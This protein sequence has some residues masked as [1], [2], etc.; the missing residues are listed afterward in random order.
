MVVVNGDSITYTPD[1]NFNGID[2]L[3]YSICDNGMPVL[4]DT[5]TVFITVDPVNDAPV[6]TIDPASTDEDIPV[7]VDV[8]GN[9]T[10]VEGDSLTTTVVGPPS[11]G[12]VVVVN[13]DSISYTPDPNFNG[14]DTLVYS[15]CDNGT[16]VLCDTDTVIITVNPVNDAPVATVDPASTDEDTPVN[17][18]VQNNDSDIDGDPLTTTIVVGPGNGTAV[19]VNGDSITYTPDPNFNGLDTLVY[20]ICDNGTPVLCDT[21]TVFI[22]VDP[23]NDVPVAV[24]DVVM[25]MEDN[26]IVIDPLNNDN[27]LADPNGGLDSN[28]V[29]IVTTPVSGTL[30]PGP[31]GTFSYLP[32]SNFCGLD[33][34]QY[35]VCDNG[36]PAPVLCDTAWVV[37]EVEC[38]NDGPIAIDDNGQ[39]FGGVPIDL[40]V[41]SNDTDIDGDSLMVSGIT[42]PPTNGTVTINPDGSITYLPP[43]GFVGL[44]TF[45][46]V[47]CDN[48]IPSLCDTACV[49]VEVLDNNDP[50]VA[51]N[52]TGST[53]DGILVTLGVLGNDTDPEG[54]SLVVTEVGCGPANGVAFLV[55][56]DSVAYLPNPGF[57]GVDSFC[58]IVCDPLGQCDT[59]YVFIDVVSTNNPPVASSDSVTTSEDPIDIVVL[60][61]DG[62]PNNDSITVSSVPCDP[63]NGSVSI[64]GG[65]LTYTPVD[66]FIGQDSFCYVI[67]DNGI[68]AMCDTAWVYVEVLPIDLTIPN[69]FTPNGDDFNDNFVIRGLTELYPENELQIFNR[70]GNIVFERKNYQNDWD[71]LFERTGEKVPDGTY[72]YKLEIEG[73]QGKALRSG[74]IVIFE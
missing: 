68:P 49:V 38:V 46:Y 56:P 17:V 12:T 40:V 52:D 43:V 45:C 26:P 51:S 29:S 1:P 10:D 71:G 48:G 50:P 5:D 4:C 9:D 44:D 59:A 34:F 73:P 30:T 54:D 11:N 41:V 32:D 23:V 39:T 69:T 8:Q 36:I 15:I 67:C 61:N 22:T 7:L 20:S 60:F 18:D 33:S 2:T 19:V 57:V 25:G 74:Y 6:A 65:I 72:F 16:P 37:I 64:N 53:N 47:I 42:T 21:D 62:D 31:G 13:G 58:Y 55:Q 3:V 66:G 24:D 63:V 70:W 35:V 27:D 28:S 14:M